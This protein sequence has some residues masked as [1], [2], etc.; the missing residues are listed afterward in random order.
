[1]LAV[2]P[3]A[4]AVLGVA[5][6]RP[7]SGCRSVDQLCV[8]GPPETLVAVSARDREPMNDIELGLIS[9]DRPRPHHEEIDTRCAC[10]GSRRRRPGISKVLAWGLA[11]A[12]AG[13]VVVAADITIPRVGNQPDDPPLSTI[14]PTGP[15]TRG[16]PPMIVTQRQ[17]VPGEQITVLVAGEVLGI[18]REGMCGLVDLRFDGR[19]VH[20]AVQYV[21][22]DPSEPHVTSAA[23][24]TVPADAV[25][26]AHEI[27]LYAPFSGVRTGPVCVEE[28]ERQAPI[29]AASVIVVAAGS[30]SP[31]SGST[32]DEECCRTQ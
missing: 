1:M 2:T 11:V 25:T 14:D 16:M 5:R 9:L 30:G 20:H 13:A 12:F 10:H 26:G 22:L 7:W 18:R 27:G 31:V 24:V 19:P 21:R 6:R 32:R 8:I 3:I 29:A 23:A 28:R 17:A 15:D 4:A